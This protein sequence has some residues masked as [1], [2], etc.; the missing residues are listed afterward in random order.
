MGLTWAY[1]VFVWALAD[2]AKVAMQALWLRQEAIK[3]RC[4]AED[5]PLPGWV[6]AMDLPGT[7]AERLAD[8]TDDAVKARSRP[9]V[10]CQAG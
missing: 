2:F 1:S 3:E 10:A 7:W 5:M 4:A 6:A 8:R 9:A